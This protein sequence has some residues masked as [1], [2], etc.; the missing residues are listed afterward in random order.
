MHIGAGSRHSFDFGRRDG[1]VISDLARGP[2]A[3]DW[4]RRP[5]PRGKVHPPANRRARARRRAR[6]GALSSGLGYLAGD[7]PH[8]EMVPIGGAVGGA[9]VNAYF[10]N[11]FNQV[12]YY[13]FGL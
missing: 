1:V 2:R 3:F 9:T 13:H 12:A 10:A 8:A 4:R 5:L 11:F 6:V 7:L